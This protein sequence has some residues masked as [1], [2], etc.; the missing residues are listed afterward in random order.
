MYPGSVNVTVCEV[1]NVPLA[2]EM[3]GATLVTA[4]H[5]LGVKLL[6][7]CTVGVIDWE[8]SLTLYWYPPQLAPLH[9]VLLLTE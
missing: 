5:A 6:P 8:T 1:V 9:T 3:V 2:G 7:V 4:V